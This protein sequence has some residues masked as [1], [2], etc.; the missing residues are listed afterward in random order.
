VVVGFEV[1]SSSA[2]LIAALF[3]AGESVIVG[4]GAFHV[5]CGIAKRPLSLF[6]F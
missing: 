5:I 6:C 3:A 1:V 4:I 2:V